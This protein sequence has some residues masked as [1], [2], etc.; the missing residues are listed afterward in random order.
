VVRSARRASTAATARHLGGEI[1]VLGLPLLVMD[2]IRRAHPLLPS[3]FHRFPPGAQQ[4]VPGLFLDDPDW[5][6]TSACVDLAVA[7]SVLHLPAAQGRYVS[8]TLIDA[9]GEP[10]A[11]LG[12]HEPDPSEGD[13][14]VA[15]PNWDGIVPLGARTV[16]APSDCVWAVSRILA[17]SA[18]DRI[19]A[20][21]LAARQYFAPAAGALGEA[22]ARATYR[23]KPLE[24]E[25][26]R[27]LA[28]VAPQLLLH[29]LAQLIDRAP[30]WARE[31]LG[32]GIRERLARLEQTESDPLDGDMTEAM[33]RGFSEGWKAVG[34]ALDE[35]A[36]GAGGEWQSSA[37]L[38][39][40]NLS[41]PAQTAQRL[42]RL[43]APVPQDVLSLRCQA[44]ETGRPLTGVERYR[45]HFTTATRP[46]AMAGWRLT[47]HDRWDPEPGD[48]IG[49]HGPL[50]VGNDGAIDILILHD[51]P[52]QRGGVNW[53]RAPAG[54]FELNL[55]LYRPAPHALSGAWRM[56]RVER[57]G[58]RPDGGPEPP[59]SATPSRRGSRHG[60]PPPDR[61]IS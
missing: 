29:R 41:L 51:P 8:V 34:A 58:S 59:L 42:G 48:V 45:I 30:P 50:V 14:L 56:P 26:M 36:A 9:A 55:R 40:G 5:I 7:P 21:A 24:L 60:P 32:V 18:E 23:L 39:G 38:G 17:R 61:R 27:R 1:F 20:E 11:S 4:L 49:D 25:S 28:D 47:A 3:G 53:L 12:S 13:I 35:M 57:L 44:D 31:D 6:H 2:A 22:A 46:P 37:E 43:G 15:A 19:E 54:Q 10:F 52:A 33:L 16:R